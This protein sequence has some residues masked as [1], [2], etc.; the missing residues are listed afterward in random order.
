[1]VLKNEPWCRVGDGINDISFHWIFLCIFVESENSYGNCRIHPWQKGPGWKFKISRYT[2]LYLYYLLVF[3]AQFQDSLI[4]ADNV[5]KKKKNPHFFSVLYYFR[6]YWFL[7]VYLSI[8]Y[9]L[10]LLT[11]LHTSLYFS[12]SPYPSLSTTLSLPLILLPSSLPILLYLSLS[13]YIGHSHSSTYPCFFP[14]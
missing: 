11:I 8:V 3:F 14:L 9:I 2:W 7:F 6:I 10:L 13:G 1:M 4:G 5:Q 12:I